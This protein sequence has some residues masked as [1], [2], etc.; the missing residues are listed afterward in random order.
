M[1]SSHVYEEAGTRTIMRRSAFIRIVGFVFVLGSRFALAQSNDV[2]QLPIRIHDY[3]RLPPGS[4]ES[5]QE[6]VHDLYAPIAVQPVWAE[7]MRPQGQPRRKLQR[8][9]RE[10]SIIILPPAMSRR[11][12]VEAET[13]GLAVVTRVDGGKVAYILFDRVCNVAAASA[14]SREDVLGTIIA[15]EL[16]HLLLPSGA[17]S[18]TGLMRPSWQ[19]LD[20]K[21]VDSEQWRFTPAQADAVRRHLRQ[22]LATAEAERLVAL[23]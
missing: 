15:H 6:R 17:H 3:A 20:F 14:A 16:G 11:L 5:A 1:A 12:R 8:D 18:E 4:I 10:W 19:L 7:T 23:R 2:L 13:V 21:G 9:P 22:T